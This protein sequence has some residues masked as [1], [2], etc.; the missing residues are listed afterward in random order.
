MVLL[1]SWLGL[2]PNTVA[3][4]PEVNEEGWVALFNGQDLSGWLCKS[5]RNI[6]IR[7]LSKSGS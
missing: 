5:R 3:Q 7:A 6:R 1:V 2:L 4:A